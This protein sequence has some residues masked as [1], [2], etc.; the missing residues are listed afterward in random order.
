MIP[1]NT[2]SEADDD[3][4]P[5]TGV[6]A[7]V[8]RLAEDF[9][10]DDATLTRVAVLFEDSRTRAPDIFVPA[11]AAL[12]DALTWLAEGGPT[13]AVH[14][15]LAEWAL[16][17]EIEPIE[18]MRRDCLRFEHALTR[19][20]LRLYADDAE[21]CSDSLLA[22]QRYTF[23]CVALLA[24]LV[25]RSQGEGGVVRTLPTPEYAAFM[26]VFRTAI[27]A[28]RQDGKQLGLLLL[29]VAR[30]EQVDRL[31]G[32]QKGEAFMLRVTRRMREGVLRKQDQ[33]GRVSRDQFACLL[34]RIVG[35]GV[36]ILAANK[37]MDALRA[38]VPLGDRSFDADVAIGIALYPDHGTDQQTLVRNGKLAA[39]AAR[40]ETERIAV[41]DP[42]QSASE[43]LNV[44]YETRLRD[45][46]E[47]SELAMGF[48]PQLDFASG[49]IAALACVLDWNDAQLGS[50]WESRALDAAESGGFIRE[51]TWW[52]YNNA[53][54]L[55]AELKAGGVDLP[56]A[57]K[58]RWGG[59]AQPDFTEFLERALKTWKVAPGQVT[60]EVHETALIG[61]LDALKNTLGRLK[62]LGVRL[63]IGGF[64]S[65]TA[66]L[67]SLAQLPLDEAK[68]S[69]SFVADM[70]DASAHAK[71]V[72]SLAHLAQDLGLSVVAAGVPDAA[73][74]AE[75][76][77]L[78][79][80]RIQGPHVGRPLSAAEILQCNLGASGPV[81]LPVEPKS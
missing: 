33:L 15:A 62:E 2:S 70:R 53:L 40:N 41:Y 56:V 27:E 20:A 35:E 34:P 52:I 65:A 7:L 1:P 61:E 63:A 59:I 3:L 22:L 11:P 80:A 29:N 36:A 60:I 10:L 69:A 5:V 58:V 30:V 31:L 18:R 51:L 49:R 72:K 38:P 9:A 47:H 71:I 43:E 67:T 44:Q 64:G 45:A 37:I 4:T 17:A 12:G 28:H 74:A 23:L 57:L 75:L 24:S 8:C 77:K 32:L 55:S 19:T 81:A 6:G 73:T 21:R 14:T 39:A 13:Q 68:I 79:C 26:E 54:R 66:R 16:D 46:L 78:G 48:A 76:E 25:A 42:K 50:V